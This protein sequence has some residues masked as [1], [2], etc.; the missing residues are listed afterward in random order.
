V[1]QATWMRWTAPWRRSNRP[2]SPANGRTGARCVSTAR[3][4][5]L[6]LACSYH[7]WHTRVAALMAHSVRSAGRALFRSSDTAPPCD[8]TFV[9]F[10]ADVVDGLRHLA[11]VCGEKLSVPEGPP[12]PGQ[13]VVSTQAIKNAVSAAIK[14]TRQRAPLIPAR[15]RRRSAQPSPSAP[16]GQPAVPSPA[17]QPAAP[18]QEPPVAAGLLTPPRPLAGA[19]K[20]A[21]LDKRRKA[22][23]AAAA[24]QR[25][26]DAAAAAADLAAGAEPVARAL[27]AELQAVAA[28]AA[29]APAADNSHLVVAPTPPRKKRA[30]KAEVAEAYAQLRKRTAVLASLGE[31]G[32]QL[33]GIHIPR[34]SA[35]HIKELGL[36]RRHKRAQIAGAAVP[37][38]P[39]G[40]QADHKCSRCGA[41]RAPWLC[42]DPRCQGLWFC[43]DVDE[44]GCLVCFTAAH[45]DPSCMPTSAAKKRKRDSAAGLAPVAP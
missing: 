29:V 7:A 36:A 20:R 13:Q 9:T 26:I 32:R 25:R 41:R 43:K 45:T 18:V 11:A 3:C 33:V 1:L 38:Q 12:G 22:E 23:E 42:T 39:K 15:D 27:N 28:V 31:D 5:Q 37:Q 44:S 21:S 14:A 24:E 34:A 17:A 16:V 8:E 4:D 35:S 30:H 19:A 40:V 2:W 10:V 6:T